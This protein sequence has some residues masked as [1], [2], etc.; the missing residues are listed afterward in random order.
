MRTY[1]KKG[2]LE[3]S[4]NA[5]VVLVLAITMLGIGISFTKGLFEGANFD[6]T[7]DLPEPTANEPVSLPGRE[8]DFV[9]KG[10]TRLNVKFYNPTAFEVNDGDYPTIFC[11]ESGNSNPHEIYPVAA[12]Q[13]LLSGRTGEY[14]LVVD[15]NDL[16]FEPGTYSCR[17]ML[18]A[19]TNGGY[20]SGTS[21]DNVVA[22]KPFIMNLKT[23]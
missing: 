4:V 20:C 10:K 8:I 3:L 2:S 14:F 5:I 13:K 11:S 16:I 23:A 12:G 1:K 17:I 7:V 15:G 21:S 9:Q 6:L 22:S 18:C 19:D